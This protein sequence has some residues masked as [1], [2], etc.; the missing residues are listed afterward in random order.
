MTRSFDVAGIEEKWQRRWAEEGAYQVDNDDPRPPFY[1]LCMYPY[2]SGP[3]HQGHVRNYTFGDLV[4]RYQT[5]RGKAVLS[6]IGFDSF[7]LP[8]ENAAIRTGTHPRQFTDERIAELKA[9]LVRL[10]AVYDWRREVRSH[11]LAYIRWNQVIFERL[12]DAGLAYRANAPVNWC[13]GCQ[14]VLANEQVLADGTCE[15]SGDLVVRR[16]LEQW[17][18]RITAY[19]DELLAGLDDL[20][21]PERVKTMQR[22]WIGRSQGAELSLAVAGRDGSDGRPPL[23]L[24]VFTTRPDTIFGMTYAVMAPEHP[25]VDELTTEG[26]RAAVDELRQMAAARSEI[27][28]TASAQGG[29]ALDKRGADTGTRVVNPFTGAEVPLYVADYVL[30]G[31]GTGA[32][33]AVPAEDERDWAFAQAYGLP[34]VRTVRP[35]EGW[36]E[37]GGEA[38]TG[39]GEKINSGFL[40][41][42]DIASAKERAIEALEERG[43]GARTVHY[44]LRDWLVSRQRYWGCPIPVVH[45]PVDGV[46]LVPSDQLPVLAPDDVAFEPTGRSPLASHEGFVHTTCPVCGGPARRETDTMDT[47]V[48]SSWYFLRF[49]DPFHEDLPFDPAAARHWMP[50]DQYIG[51]IEHAILH[52]LYARFF[53]RALVD[54]GIAPG[55][56]RE[57]FQRLFTQGMIRMDGTKMS[58]SKGNLIS[59][60]RYFDSV[61]ADGLRLFHLFVGPPADDFDWTAQTDQLIEGCGRFLDRLWRLMEA[62][63][64]H[65]TEHPTEAPHDEASDL[66]LRRATHRTIAQ[67][68]ADLDRWS[69]NTAVAHCMELANTVQR[70]LRSDRGPAPE[71]IG[72]AC[73]TLLLLL[74]PMTPHVTAE[75]WERRH[76]G[77]AALHR[78]AWPSPDPELLA[79]ETV[80]MVVQVNGKLRDRLDVPASIGEEEARSAALASPK[81]QDA[82]GG[83]APSRI[84]V[85]PPRLV[86]VVC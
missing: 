20:E 79:E 45:C 37:S 85:R 19:A 39:T 36:E 81:V 58:K 62:A 52:L 77:V 29:A 28:R 49:C 54:T 42:L 80:T 78:Q 16:D 33:M 59:P 26:Q 13:P 32:I 22:N 55:I 10:G 25:L 53:T 2:P 4:V 6:P 74:A 44:R 18:F 51:G 83:A 40:D 30:M 65:A 67:V 15:R 3:A 57:P 46:V 66:A 35:P 56:G 61:G 69:Y 70:A 73:D 63:D 68:T 48:D 23:A 84:V 1:A 71:T 21:W 34:V 24:R 38:Y 60:A 8:A 7:G 64:E 41:G 9:S 82:L 72:E 17:F 27:E 5:M 75:L 47:F 43:L 11:D 76:P 14:T 86:N 31:Y 12:Y 50:V